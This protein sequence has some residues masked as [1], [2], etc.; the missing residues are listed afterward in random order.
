V[1][2]EQKRPA[3]CLQRKNA[4]NSG[5]DV[6]VTKQGVIALAGNSGEAAAASAGRAKLM[7]ETS[8]LSIVIPTG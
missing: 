8:P 6:R 3:V 5:V 7:Q 4:A 2:R 1:L